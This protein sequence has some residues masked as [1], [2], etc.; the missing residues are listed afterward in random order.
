M[1]PHKGLIQSKPIA[2]NDIVSD[3]RSSYEVPFIY[4]NVFIALDCNG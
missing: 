2:R 3:Q 4:N 1:H